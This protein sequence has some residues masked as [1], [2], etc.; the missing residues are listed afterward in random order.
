MAC[1]KRCTQ[2]LGIPRQFLSV[3]KTYSYLGTKGKPGHRAMLSLS[4]R[5]RKET[6]VSITRGSDC[7]GVVS[8]I[9]V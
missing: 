1:T 4:L 7:L 8:S 2:E 6:L 5:S 9:V 3:D